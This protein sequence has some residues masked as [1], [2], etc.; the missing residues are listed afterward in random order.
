MAVFEQLREDVG[1]WWENFSQ[2]WSQF[3][4]RA[5]QA[6]TRFTPLKRDEEDSSNYELVRHTPRLGVLASEVHEGDDDVVVRLEAPGLEKD[7]F[8][9]QVVGDT[10]VVRGEKRMEREEKRGHYH[11]MECA[12]GSFQRALPLPAEVDAGKTKAKYRNGV[13]HITLPKIAQGRRHRVSVEVK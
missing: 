4:R 7:D 6:I 12:Y 10:L 2:E 1:R 5:S 13:L 11:V 3:M 8:H 9:V